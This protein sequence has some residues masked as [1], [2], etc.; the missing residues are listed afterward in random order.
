MTTRSTFLPEAEEEW[1]RSVVEHSTFSHRW[2]AK[3]MMRRR[4]SWRRWREGRERAQDM[5]WIAWGDRRR[6]FG[7]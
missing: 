4:P 1:R 5:G 7:G 2:M 6:R 3:A